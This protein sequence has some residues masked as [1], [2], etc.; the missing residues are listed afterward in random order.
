MTYCDVDFSDATDDAEQVEFFNTTKPTARKPYLCFE[1][2]EYI[3]KGDRYQRT[4]YKFEGKMSLER[5]CLSC[6]EAK[7]EFDYNI[8]GGAFWEHM[9]EEWDNGANVQGC[10]ARLT[11]ARA[12]A[13]MLRMWQAWKGLE[14][15]APAP[16]EAPPG[17]GDGRGG[18]SGG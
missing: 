14:V 11:T 2:K 18:A 1:C 5:L 16:E 7:A 4:A 12:R 6:A 15:A 3:P 9:A 8:F 10:I 17:A 13:L